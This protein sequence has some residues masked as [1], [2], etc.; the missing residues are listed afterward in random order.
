MSTAVFGPHGYGEAGRC[1]SLASIL[2]HY[3]HICTPAVGLISWSASHTSPQAR[4][5]PPPF[6]MV[7]LHHRPFSAHI[8][9]Q[10]VHEFLFLC[11]DWM[12]PSDPPKTPPTPSHSIHDVWLASRKFEHKGELGYLAPGAHRQLNLRNAYLAYEI[13]R[14]HTFEMFRTIWVPRTS[15]VFLFNLCRGVFPAFR[16]YSQ[17]LII[18]EVRLL[19]T[20]GRGRTGPLTDHVTSTTASLAHSLPILHLGTPFAPVGHRMRAHAHRER[21]RHLCVR[22]RMYPHDINTL[23]VLPQDK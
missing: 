10:S 4:V 1:A 13:L 6:K 5:S 20:R 7:L 16:G 11:R 9:S 12:F 17:A 14:V 2:G 22:S 18:D 3:H 23:T 15:L 21:S 8:L 19:I